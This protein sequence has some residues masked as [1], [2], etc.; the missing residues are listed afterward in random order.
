MKLKYKKQALYLLASLLMSSNAMAFS[1]GFDFDADRLAEIREIFNKASNG[2]ITIEKTFV[3]PD[4]LTGVV[5]KAD[6]NK[7]IAW[8]TSNNKI[9]IGLLAD[10]TGKNL[11]IEAQ[12]INI[13]D[14]P[15]PVVSK[16]TPDE[17]LLYKPTTEGGALIDAMRELKS[18]PWGDTTSKKEIYVFG[19]LNCHYCEDLYKI[20][21]KD[22]PK[23]AGV[24]INWIPVAVLGEK[25]LIQA[26]QLLEANNPTEALD[27]HHKNH[28]YIKSVINEA[29]P[30]LPAI[31][32]SIKSST[33]LLTKLSHG[34]P[35]MV[36]WN[37]KES[38]ILPGL[39]PAEDV[40]KAIEA[41]RP[42]S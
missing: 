1:F 16:A 2:K 20:L 7:G 23:K 40:K 21:L 13:G 15:N 22:D 39:P 31:I 5:M 27:L 26:A 35:A 38:V 17:P 29:D 33:A 28:Q 12:K 24:K 32:D 10:D 3:G 30:K 18:V 41:V 42:L 6:G 25:S 34:T 37:G 8:V 19:D 14:I 36:Y 9:I 11:S 4:D